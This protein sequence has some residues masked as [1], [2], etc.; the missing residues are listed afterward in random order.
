MSTINDV[1]HRYPPKL[2]SIYLFNKYRYRIFETQYI[3]FV[4]S[5]SKFSLFHNSNVFGSCII[6]ILYTGVLKLKEN[7]SGAKRLRVEACCCKLFKIV[8]KVVLG[9]IYYYFTE[10][11]YEIMC[12]CVYVH[13]QTHTHTHTYIR[14][15]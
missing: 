10:Q 2:Y 6:H 1:P 15:R 12:V 4:F 3:L 11:M 5:S 7:N 13:T 9:S 8:F 14:L